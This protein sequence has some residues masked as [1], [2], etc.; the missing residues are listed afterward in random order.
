MSTRYLPVLLVA[1][2]L[3]ASLEAAAHHAF[4]PVYDIE[5]QV[6]VT[7]TVVEFRLVNP[8]ASMTVRSVDADGGSETWTVDFD[9]RVNLTVAGWTEDTIKAGENITVV[10]NPTH[11]GSPRMFFIHLDREDGTRL[12]RPFK[13]RFNSIDAERRRSREARDSN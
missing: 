5:R 7:G 13:S 2:L 11:A 1:S 4:A 9:G 10:G 12:L 8:H 6:S 3:A